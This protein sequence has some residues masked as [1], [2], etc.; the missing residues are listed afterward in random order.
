MPT[1]DPLDEYEATLREVR[2]RAN[3][4]NQGSAELEAEERLLRQLLDELASAV[5]D[6]ADHARHPD[7]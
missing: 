6:A 7:G 2:H 3:E 5:N 4:L 1:D